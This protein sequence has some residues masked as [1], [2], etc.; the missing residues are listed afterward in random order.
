MERW[1]G[2]VAKLFAHGGL[3]NK[4]VIDHMRSSGFGQTSLKGL[5]D[6]ALSTIARVGRSRAGRSA[7]ATEFLR[8]ALYIE[9]PLPAGINAISKA[10]AVGLF[11]RHRIREWIEN[12]DDES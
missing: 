6:E 9:K 7:E 5:A 12:G 2:E 8:K 3:D 10:R 11:F 4:F 1:H